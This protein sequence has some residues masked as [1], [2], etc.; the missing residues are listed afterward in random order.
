M[1]P[2]AYAELDAVRREFRAL[3][4]RWSAENPY[5]RPLQER[6]R[7]ERGGP[8]YP[9]ETPIVYNRALDEIGPD[10]DIRVVLVADNPGKKEQLSVNNRYLVGQS[11]KLAAAWFGRELGLDF[12]RR[13]LVLNK[14][15]IHTPR[16][17]ELRHLLALAG[18]DRGRLASLLAESQRAMAGFAHR[19]HLALCDTVLWVSGLGEIRE[20][21]LFAAYREEMARLFAAAGGA[22]DSGA[23][24]T[25]EFWAFNHFSMNRFIVELG[26]KSDPALGLAENLERIG[27]A[28]R[29]RVFG[30]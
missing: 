22:A 8:A 15:P 5:L 23:A 6:L 7:D 1:R 13:V 14:T 12:G 18:A 10:G 30:F 26:R 24:P 25:R 21:G 9:V 29:R 27:S 11:G 28:N 19:L 17:A 3:V 16:T 4:D 20:G 2:E